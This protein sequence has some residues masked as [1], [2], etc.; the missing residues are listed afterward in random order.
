MQKAKAR[1]KARAKDRA[2]GALYASTADKQATE[3]HSAQEQ[4]KTR[5]MR[6][7]GAKEAQVGRSHDNAT[8][9]KDGDTGQVI[10]QAKGK[11]KEANRART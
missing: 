6:N 10:V 11:E 3:Q 2:H 5:A 4:P 7:H 8:R 1:A 9:V